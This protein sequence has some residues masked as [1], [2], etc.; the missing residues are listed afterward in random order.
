MPSGTPISPDPNSCAV[1]FEYGRPNIRSVTSFFITE[2]GLK[3]WI[4]LWKQERGGCLVDGSM[5]SN[6]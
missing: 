1:A 4:R 2:F 6:L 5:T 3:V